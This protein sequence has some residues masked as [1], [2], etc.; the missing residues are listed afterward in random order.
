MQSSLQMKEFVLSYLKNKTPSFY[1]Y[2]N[3]EHTLYV[4]D[5]AIE[6]GRYEKCTEGE[7]ALISAA[8][9]WHET[10]YINTYA[11]HEEASCALARKYLPGY[12]YSN[13]D[14]DKV[15][16]MI[17]ATKIP[18]SPKN[19]LEE[20]LADA[21]LEYLGTEHA[22]IIAYN[23]FRELQTI[24]PSLTNAAWNKIQISFLQKHHYFTSFCK[25]NREAG[26]LAYLSELVKEIE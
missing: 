4:L 5:K 20:I 18:Q 25:E 21:D 14:I 3:P 15:C 23:L 12:G 1:Y 11:D 16:G 2:H 17:M 22:A 10:G 24:N 9:L 13:P 19:K 6:I 7:I 26:K 8:A